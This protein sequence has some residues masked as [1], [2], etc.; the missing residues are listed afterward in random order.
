MI[1]VGLISGTSAD[2]IEAAVTRLEEAP[3][4]LRWQLLAH[5]HIPYRPELRAE[6]FACFRPEVSTVDRLCAL[7]FALGRAFGEAAL[8]AIA[9]AG[10]TPRQVDL[11]GSH[12]Q[13]LWHIPSGPQASTL[14]LGEPAVIAEIAGLPVVSG[15]RTRDMA[16]GGQG[17]PLAAYPDALFFR[18]ESLIRA[19][20]NIGGIANVTYL[21]PQAGGELAFDTGPGNMLIDDVVRRATDGAQT[22]D[23]DGALAA[24]GRV[25]AALLD[26]LLQEPYLRQAPPKTTGRELF[27]TPYGARVWERAQ[28]HG[29]TPEDVLATVTAFT[30]HSIARAYRDF[31]PR[32]PDEVIL[33]GGGARN[34]TL[35]AMLREQLVPATVL[36]VDAL[37]LPSE[38]KEALFFAVLA[39]ES[40]HS[41]PGNLPAATGAARPVILGSHTPR[42]YDPSQLVSAPGRPLWGSALT[43]ARNPQTEHIDELSTPELVRLIN[44]EDAHVAP[45]VAAELPRI[46]EAIDRV[47][48]RMGA[49]GR[50]IYVGAGTAGR[51]GV[52]D[53]AE[54]PPT[55]G[56][57]PTQVLAL[58]AGGPHAITHSVEGAED[59]PAAGARDVADLDVSA[60]D[61]VVGIS[62]SGRTPYVLGA[63]QE[64][65]RRG[66][67]T[68]SLACNRPSALELLADVALAPLVGPEVI[69]GST[70]LKAG[71]AQKMTL[72]MLSTGVMIR[73]GKTLGNLMV[74]VQ[75]LNAKLRE[76]A[77][78]IVAEV[79]GLSLEEAAILLKQCEGE[80]KTAI[81]ASLVG[82]SPEAARAR[83]HAVGGVV[84][85][86]LRD[87]R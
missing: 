37:G 79:C 34:P 33:C 56:T 28:T 66:A 45:A 35:V 58:M 12:G 68:I 17:A 31:L 67:L 77:K 41:R 78:R 10:L 6:L 53:A 42:P 60:G 87:G 32:T 55:F 38:A 80:V 70:R 36:T 3:P 61:T 26:E 63:L 74:D 2:G 73:L 64:A 43:E 48:E 44:A 46:A 25:H 81:I 21:P 57:L 76:R 86:A 15:F 27:G 52:L 72:N 1:V 23:R 18:H 71:T 69:T 19:V 22:F 24:R 82:L 83:L 50:L 59:D 9:A 39:Y 65:R 75:P 47:A 13:T 85:A 20:Q 51:L 14:Q 16:A 62:A 4:T 7:N 84:R 5:H 29:L 8:R 30:A 40:W 49:G 54:C 11:I